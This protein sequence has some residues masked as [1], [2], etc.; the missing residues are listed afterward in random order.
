MSISDLRKSA[1]KGLEVTVNDMKIRLVSPKVAVTQPLKRQSL[2]NAKKMAPYSK[3]LMEAPVE[4][5]MAQEEVVIK[6]VAACLNA[7]LESLGDDEDVVTEE[8]ATSILRIAGGE[9]SELARACMR[10]CGLGSG[11]DKED[12]QNVKLLMDQ[13]EGPTSS[14]EQPDAPS[15]T[16]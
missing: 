1:K 4:L 15:S 6:A 13:L 11:N 3:K 9:R 14:V 2:E 16:S 10:L 7:E 12:A 8:E 5:L